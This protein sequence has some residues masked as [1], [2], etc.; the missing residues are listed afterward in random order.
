MPGIHVFSAFSKEDVDGRDQSGHDEFNYRGVAR[1][2]GDASQ[3][4][5]TANSLFFRSVTSMQPG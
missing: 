2:R 4:Y 5:I 3:S 1:F